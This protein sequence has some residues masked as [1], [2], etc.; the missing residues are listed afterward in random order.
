MV[1]E[2]GFEPRQSES[3]SLVLP[4]HNSAISSRHDKYNTPFFVICQVFFVIFLKNI[5]KKI[6]ARTICALIYIDIHELTSLKTFLTCQALLLCFPY[7]S[8]TTSV[9]T[10][11][12]RIRCRARPRHL[13]FL[14][15]HLR[16]RR[17]RQCRTRRWFSP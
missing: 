9:R 6:K 4:L 15:M 8:R 13:P 11:Q 12:R 1:A 2:L 5:H 16:N 14:R 10:G 3:E 17:C 7:L